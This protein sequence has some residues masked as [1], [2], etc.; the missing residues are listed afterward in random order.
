MNF[1]KFLTHDRIHLVHNLGLLNGHRHLELAGEKIRTSLFYET[2]RAN[3]SLTRMIILVGFLFFISSLTA[4]ATR[5][6][7]MYAALYPTVN[8]LIVTFTVTIVFL[9]KSASF[10]IYYNF[11]RHFRNVFKDLLYGVLNCA[12]SSCGFGSR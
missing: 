11:D 6:S 5:I 9:A 12:K 3:E 2:K 1:L 7:G 10:F 4:T 8:Q